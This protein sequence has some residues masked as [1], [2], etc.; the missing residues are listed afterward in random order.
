MRLRRGHDLRRTFI[1]LA[2]EDGAR[3]DV[4]Q[5]IT[6]APDAADVMS[7][8]T[9]YPWSTLCAE[10]AKL[11]IALP[12][13]RRARAVSSRVETAPVPASGQDKAMVPPSSN[14]AA[15]G[16]LLG[17]VPEGSSRTR[18]RT[19]ERPMEPRRIPTAAPVPV[20]ADGALRSFGGIP[21]GTPVATVATCSATCSTEISNDFEPLP[22]FEPGTYGLRNR[23]STPELQRQGRGYLLPETGELRKRAGREEMRPEVAVRSIEGRAGVARE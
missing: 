1:T 13:L 17:L 23:C 22:G 8:Y 2:Q 5:V 19:D 12:E 14:P 20:E 6:H 10:V 9:T 7:L 11:Q 4:L 21:G 3:R 18:P 15:L 16:A